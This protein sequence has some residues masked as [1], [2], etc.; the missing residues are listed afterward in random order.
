MT[1]IPQVQAPPAPKVPLLRRMKPFPFAIL[2]LGGIFFL[3]QFVWGVPVALLAGGVTVKTVNFVRWAQAF[4]QVAFM[5]VPTIL[6]ARYRHGDV[7]EVLKLRVPEISELVVTMISVF[8]LQQMLQTYMIVQDAI[9][10]PAELQKLVTSIRAQLEQL[11]TL[12]VGAGSPLEFLGVVAVVALIPAIAEELL[13]RGLIQSNLELQVGGFWAAMLT[14]VI[15]GMS[16]LNPF[17]V[18]P[19]VVL[20]AYLGFVVYRSG[21]IINSMSVHFF[22]NFIACA[23]VYLHLDDNFIALHPTGKATSAL[24]LANFLLFSVVFVLGTLYFL[25]ITRTDDDEEDP[26]QEYF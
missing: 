4:G 19:L 13:F 9:P 12:L 18:V 1:E 15:F 26:D 16:H 20:G 25:H 23:V 21:S 22:N 24:V 7:A 3:Y 14:G 11:M 8:A 10:L 2:A 17:D 5:L 6:L